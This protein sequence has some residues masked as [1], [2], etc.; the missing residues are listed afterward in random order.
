MENNVNDNDKVNDGN[1]NAKMND[2]DKR[3]KVLALKRARISYQRGS[4]SEFEHQIHLAK[5][6]IYKGKFFGYYIQIFNYTKMLIFF[7]RSSKFS[8]VSSTNF[9]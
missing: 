4:I 1:N 7:F 2:N 3:D 8:F 9:R 5:R 6:R